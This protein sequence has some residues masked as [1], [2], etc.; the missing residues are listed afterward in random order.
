[1]DKISPCTKKTDDDRVYEEGKRRA[2]ECEENNGD[3]GER[4]LLK[5]E[6]SL[7]TQPQIQ[8]QKSRGATRF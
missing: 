8:L 5:S 3:G 4:V 2:D 7:A 1:M 6:W